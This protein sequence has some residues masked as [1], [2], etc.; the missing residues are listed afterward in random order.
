LFNVTKLIP[1][2]IRWSRK[3]NGQPELLDHVLAS[4][5]LMPRVG[6]LRQVP[7]VTILN[8]DT[9][10]L[11]GENPTVNGVIPDHAPV[12]AVFV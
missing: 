3:H 9:P 7:I 8:E 10:N 1:A 6:L 2:D 4:H 5:G 12:T 11:L